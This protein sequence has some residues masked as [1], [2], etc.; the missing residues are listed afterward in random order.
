M[1]PSLCSIP[2]RGVFQ[3]RLG[4]FFLAHDL[5]IGKLWFPRRP[6]VKPMSFRPGGYHFHVQRF[7][8]RLLALAV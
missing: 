4:G 7:E 6:S 2:R 3:R 1:C 8:N 5:P